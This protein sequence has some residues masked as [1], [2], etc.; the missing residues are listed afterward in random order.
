VVVSP[1][2][3]SVLDPTPERSLTLVTQWLQAHANS[4]ADRS[5]ADMIPQSPIS[6]MGVLALTSVIV[7]MF[8]IDHAARL[9]RPVTIVTRI[10]SAI[11]CQPAI[12]CSDNTAMRSPSTTSSDT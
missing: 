8:L 10:A 7:F 11:S 4:Q 2:D 6:I 1:D 12:R 5:S 9:L 3:V